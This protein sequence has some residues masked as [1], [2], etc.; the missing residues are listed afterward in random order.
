MTKAELIERVSKDAGP[1]VSKKMVT[2]MVEAVFE[3]LHKAIR[4]DKRF[5]YPGFGTWAIK[6]RKARKGRNPKTGEVILIAPTRTVAFKPAP[7]F[8]ASLQ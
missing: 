4:K 6:K 2:F 7:N 5:T 1:V 3:H 8:K